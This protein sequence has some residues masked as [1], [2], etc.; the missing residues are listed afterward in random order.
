MNIL[1]KIK[2]KEKKSLEVVSNQWLLYKKTSVKEST[3]FRYKYIV[4]K[5]IIP[6]FKGKNINYFEN[7]DY[8]IY[9]NYLS[10]NVSNKTLKDIMLVF[11]AILKFCERKF[12]ID[13]KLDLMSMP[14]CEQ[15]EINILTDKE[16]EKLETYCLKSSDLRNIGIAICLNTGLR[17]GE[18]CALTWNNI[19]LSEKF[20]TINKSLQRI[21]KGKK[22]TI[23]QINTPKTRR[24]IRKIPISQKIYNKLYTLKKINNYKGEEY[25]LTGCKEKYIEPRNYQYE[26]KKCLHTCKIPNYN[27]HIL[28]H[29]FATN[30]IKIG[31]D[32]KSLSELLGH[33]NVNITLNKY[34]HSSYKIQK[35][36][37]EKSVKIFQ[38]FLKCTKNKIMSVVKQIY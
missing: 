17:I 13:Y 38:K 21:Y 32:I 33:S 31:M 7:Y 4:N 24:S 2:F 9:I 16:K 27:F 23:V 18:I 19:N 29:T 20:F 6:Y 1:K 37:L 25:F 35:K 5:Y 14:K 11:K 26:F 15:E 12:D 34:V 22:D 10:K 30:C 3:Y 8:N 28:R 36:F